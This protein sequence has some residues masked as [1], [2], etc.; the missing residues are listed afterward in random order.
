MY[1]DLNAAG[2]MPADRDSLSRRQ[3]CDQLKAREN[4]VSRWKARHCV[5]SQRSNVRDFLV[6]KAM[7][8]PDTDVMILGL[9]QKVT[10][11]YL[12]KYE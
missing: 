10:F 9:Y 4:V 3:M 7:E 5:R 2:T 11:K 12:A 8:V 1:T 6:E